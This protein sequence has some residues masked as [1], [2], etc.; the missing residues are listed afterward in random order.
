[1]AANDD[2]TRQGDIIALWLTGY[3]EDEIAG[4]I[5]ISAATVNRWLLKSAAEIPEFR[6]LKERYKE[7]VRPRDNVAS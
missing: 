1:M 6:E 2:P 3:T 5:G 4:G 7:N